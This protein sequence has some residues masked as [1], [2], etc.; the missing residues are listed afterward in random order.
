MT[1]ATFAVAVQAVKDAESALTKQGENKNHYEG[2][3]HQDD[4]D[5]DDDNSIICA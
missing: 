5:D 3:H 4:N 1:F 2:E